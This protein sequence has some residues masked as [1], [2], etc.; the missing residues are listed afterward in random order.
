MKKNVKVAINN[1]NIGAN[2]QIDKSYIHKSI[3]IICRHHVFADMIVK[4]ARTNC[5][6]KYIQYDFLFLKCIENIYK[7]LC[8]YNLPTYF[9]YFLYVCI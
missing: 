7:M 5:Y 8:I 3:L 2:R 4:K 9:A 6:N 1:S